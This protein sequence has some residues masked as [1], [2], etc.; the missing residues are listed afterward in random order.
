L[1]ALWPQ[2]RPARVPSAEPVSIELIPVPPPALS[3]APV[4]PPPRVRERRPA[5]VS[6]PPAPAS[7]PPAEPSRGPSPPAPPSPESSLSL[8]NPAAPADGALLDPSQGSPTPRSLLPTADQLARAGIE[9]PQPAAPAPRGP[10]RW[11][12]GMERLARADTARANQARGKATPE[13]FEL[14]RE[15]ERRYR[16]SHALVIDLAKAEAGRS[17]EGQRWLGRYLGGFFKE[18]P[19][20]RDKPFAPD[21]AF[22]RGVETAALDWDTRVCV[23]FAADG[24]P[25][26][27][28]DHSSGIAGLDRLAKETIVQAAGRQRAGLG[29][30]AR[31]CFKFSA[32]LSRVPPVPVLACGLDARLRPECVYPLKEVASTRVQLDGVE[33][34]A[35]ADARR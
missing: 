16:P 25:D 10:S 28:L 6:P 19:T 3:P 22:R 21:A 12:Q 7:P 23:R 4:A 11:Q 24:T 26:V 5:P 15:L 29:S 9:V 33:L 31:A 27:E 14:L 30:I 35:Q 20:D 8:R 2:A 18:R 13:A 1:L 34:D 17:R 32:K